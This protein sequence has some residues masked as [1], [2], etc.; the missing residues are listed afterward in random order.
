MS[1][2]LLVLIQAKGGE[3]LIKKSA[4]LP[5]KTWWFLELIASKFYPLVYLRYPKKVNDRTKH[6]LT[7]PLLLLGKRMV[8]SIL[9]NPLW[10]S[11][12]LFITAF[13]FCISLSPAN[14]KEPSYFYFCFKP[15]PFSRSALVPCWTIFR[16]QTLPSYGHW[17][18]KKKQ[19]KWAV[20]GGVSVVGF[21]K[22]L[23]WKCP[24][25]SDI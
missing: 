19:G 22:S 11:H 17:P 24:P 9:E 20:G 1:I 6:S 15:V 14:E 8:F 2:I 16:L 5:A 12:L 21:M 18:L 3:R 25:K 13:N 23:T 7:F 10:S 4:K